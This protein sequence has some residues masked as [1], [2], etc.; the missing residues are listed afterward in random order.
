MTHSQSNVLFV[1]SYPHVIAGQQRTLLSLLSEAPRHGIR[2]VVMLPD[3]GV[4]A[5]KLREE[6]HDVEILPYPESLSRYGGAIY[7]D[8]IGKRLGVIRDTAKYILSIRR[9]LKQLRP[10]AVFC[11]DMRGLLTVGVAAK[12]LGIPNIIWDKLDKPH[13]V[14]DW[15][16]LPLV[17]SNPIISWPVADKYPRWQRRWYRD[18]IVRIADGVE[19]SRFEGVSTIR[20][21]LGY[22]P[23]D[24]LIGIV[25][26][27]TPR[28]GHDLLLEILPRLLDRFPN[29]RVVVIGSWTDDQRDRSYF[30]SLPNRLNV[31]VDFLGQREDIPALMKTLDVLVVP[32]RFEGLGLVTLEAM[33]CGKPVVGASV[34]GIPEAIID[35]QTG[36]LFPKDDSEALLEKLSELLA[37]R[38]S[39]NAMGRTGQSRVREHFDRQKKMSEICQLIRDA[40]CG[41]V[42]E[43]SATSRHV[44]NRVFP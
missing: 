3:E 21:E 37:D 20:A 2:P 9:R 30:E 19:V 7:R 31:R 36:L 39:A 14:L 4:Y 18:R 13:G 23:D 25:G 38:D 22:K 34:G 29:V 5:G 17:A 15:F 24:Q 43:S 28:K 41:P 1:E 40:C 44:R 42:R 12:S 11:N 33:A 6:G 35:G 8:S 26:T 16:Q 10:A 27:V 32:S